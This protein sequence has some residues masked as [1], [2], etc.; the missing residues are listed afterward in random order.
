MQ[1]GS[2]RGKKSSKIW[3]LPSRC[4]AMF[5]RFGL[6][7]VGG[8]YGWALKFKMSFDVFCL[9]RLIHCS[10]HGNMSV[11]WYVQWQSAS[12]QV[13]FQAGR[14]RLCRSL[15]PKTDAQTSVFWCGPK[16]SVDSW[17]A[18]DDWDAN[19]QQFLGFFKQFDDGLR[20]SQHFLMKPKG[21]DQ[22]GSESSAVGSSI[23]AWSSH[24]DQRPTVNRPVHRWNQPPQCSVAWL[25][26]SSHSATTEM[27]QESV[28]E[29]I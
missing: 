26:W 6:I 5:K 1:R 23:A 28:E 18:W 10:C 7:A 17:D 19:P 15:R 29:G 20:G 4:W 8:G 9:A 13:R 22:K 12:F 14:L 27:T 2:N 16:S 25:W 3:R 11:A 24:G 21:S